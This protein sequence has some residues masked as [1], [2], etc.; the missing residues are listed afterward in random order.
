MTKPKQVQIDE[1]T[2]HFFTA[3]C[4]QV[5][6][7]C[8]HALVPRAIDGSGLSFAQRVAILHGAYIGLAGRVGMADHFPTVQ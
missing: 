7:L 4:E 8:D 3:E 6:A 2:L 1:S 5:H